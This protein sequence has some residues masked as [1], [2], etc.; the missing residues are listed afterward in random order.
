MSNGAWEHVTT[1]EGILNGFR[2]CNY[3]DF[4]GS[5]VKLPS[6]LYD[7]IKNNKVPYNLVKKRKCFRR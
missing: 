1:D 5:I 4:D 3:F 7:T 2:Q 6:N